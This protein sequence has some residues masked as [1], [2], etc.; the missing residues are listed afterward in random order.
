[1]PDRVGVVPTLV[2]ERDLE[3]A[4]TYLFASRG[5]NT[6]RRP[7]IGQRSGKT[8]REPE[9]LVE[10]SEQSVIARRWGRVVRQVDR[11]AEV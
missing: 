8:A 2:A 11:A 6:L 7:V 1:V 9:S 3:E 10:L 4:L 5:N